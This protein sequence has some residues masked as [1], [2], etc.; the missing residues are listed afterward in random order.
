MS[1]NSNSGSAIKI[2]VSEA[3]MRWLTLQALPW[4][5]LLLLVSVAGV[6]A[7]GI[8]NTVPFIPQLNEE[9]RTDIIPQP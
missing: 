4:L 1:D 5:T 6:N 9:S 3:F 7:F 2:E 8:E